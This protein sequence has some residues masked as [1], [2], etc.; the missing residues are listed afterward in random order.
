MPS[1]AKACSLSFDLRRKT[2]PLD[3][4]HAHMP[5]ETAAQIGRAVGPT[6]ERVAWLDTET[7]GLAGGT[8]TYVFLVGIGAVEDGNFVLTQYFMRDLG[9]EIDML[10]ALAEHL[11]RFDALVTFNGSRFD[12]P[13]LQTRFLLSRLRHDFEQSEHLDV[14][15]LARRLWY[16]RLGGYS[17]ALLEQMVLKVD[18]F[19]DVAGWM[20][21]SLYVQYLQTGDLEAIEPIFAHNAADLLSLLSLH[22]LTGEMVTHPQ[23]TRVAVDWSGLGHLLDARRE[24]AAAAECYRVALVDERDPSVRR[25]TVTALARHL[26]R[27][28]QTMELLE[29]W[30]G[31]I[32]R[33]VLPGWLILERLAMLWEWELKDAR[34][35]LACTEQALDTLN[36]STHNGSTLNGGGADPVRVRMVHRRDRLQRKCATI[37]QSLG[38]LG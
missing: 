33:E 26:R 11:R 31:E 29:L 14:M 7:T 12:L 19:V 13:L 3:H 22:G 16:R 17:M 18:R 24:C 4:V 2:W 32:Q 38:S 20:I 15:S 25:R 30:D 36:G 10:E 37:Y 1:E 28:R 5:L 21:P 34:H 35:A 6:G 8:G 9:G 23:Q 27:T